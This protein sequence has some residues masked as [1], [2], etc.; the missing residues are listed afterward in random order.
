MRYVFM[1]LLLVLLSGCGSNVVLPPLK[2]T[3]NTTHN[4]KFKPKHYKSDIPYQNLNKKNIQMPREG[5][6][7]AYLIVVSKELQTAYDNYLGGDPY[8]ALKALDI[9]SKKTNDT[10]ELWQI[11]FLKVKLYMLLGLDADAQSEISTCQKYEK[12][13]FGHTLNSTALRG[14]IYVMEGRFDEARSDFNSVLLSIGNWEL[15]TSYT[16]PPSNM[17]ELVAVATAQLRAYTGMAA[18]YIMEGNYKK[19]YFWAK[20][21]EARFNAIHYV[22]NDSIYGMFFHTHLDSYYGRAMNMAILAS[23]ILTSSQDTK[24]AEFYYTQAIRFFNAIGYKKGK[25]ITLALKAQTLATIGKPDEANKVALDAISLANTTKLYD[26]IWRIETLRGK[27]L[28]K[29]GKTDEAKKA[30]RDAANV[31]DLVSGN[32]KTDYSKRRFGVG[33]E[34]LVL[35]LV[36]LDLADKN[37]KEL[38]LDVEKGRARAFVDVMRNRAVSGSKYANLLNEI[39]KTDKEIKKLTIESYAPHAKNNSKKQTN[40]MLKRKRL[41]KELIQKDVELAS[42][43]STFSYSL[44][45]VQNAL[46]DDENILYFLP[47]KKDE[48]IKALLIKKD[49]VELKKFHLSQ[50]RLSTIMQQ[51]LED[52]GVYG[53]S[54][55]EKNRALKKKIKNKTSLNIKEPL[56]QLHSLLPLDDI[57]AKRVYVVGSGATTYIPWLSYDKSLEV[58]ILPNAS[59]ILHNF[60]DNKNKNIV[61]VGNPDFGGELPQLDGTLKEARALGSFYGEKPLLFRNATLK[62][63]KENIGSGAKVL[64]LATHGVFYSDEPLKSAIFLSKDSK[65]YTLTAKE[66]FAS[67][68][69]ADLVVLSACETG[70]GVNVAGDDL[71]G[72]PRSFFLGGSRVVVSSL[73]PISDD[74]T[75]EFMLE[76]HKFAKNGEYEKG[77]LKAKELLKSKGY[78]DS[79]YGAFVLYGI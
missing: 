15:P 64:H 5:E 54:L 60:K 61:I 37:Y 43:V 47:L 45:D 32:L 24:K 58:S 1:S 34:E 41:V 7:N 42:V 76:F 65:L 53:E 44:D 68:L 70:M 67:P 40:L 30:F 74:G 63:V 46:K 52:I 18:S 2:Q 56:K 22:G 50:S 51:Y 35:N 69:K 3:L 31:I 10:L 39:Q 25:I 66:I 11:S 12:I 26:F 28:L 57:K 13:H 72:L 9:A 36:K 29:D 21:A 59:W 48:D 62:N 4:G 49:N 75:K 16:L 14:E 19:A 17:A 8:K 78:S 27:I 33:K 6:E 71:L 20:E 55:S 38:F 79:V 77:L 23:S 73:W